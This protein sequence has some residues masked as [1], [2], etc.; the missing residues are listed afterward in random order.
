ML[1]VTRAYPELEEQYPVR[2]MGVG[3]EKTGDLRNK[4]KLLLA[5]ASTRK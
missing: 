4:A 3:I 2:T 5:I 1:A